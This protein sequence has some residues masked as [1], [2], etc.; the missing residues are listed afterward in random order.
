LFRV[1]ASRSSGEIP[2]RERSGGASPPSDNLKPILYC[3]AYWS[4]DWACTLPYLHPLPA[5]DYLM[6]IF[7]LVIFLVYMVAIVGF[8]LS[9]SFRKRSS[10]DYTTGGGRLPAW[11]I[12]MPIFAT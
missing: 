9:F 12:V 3:K 2:N 5:P 4:P 10:S 8:G 1:G 11:A 7:D 6:P